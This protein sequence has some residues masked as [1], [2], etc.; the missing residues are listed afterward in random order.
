MKIV[1]L[2]IKID[3]LNEIHAYCESVY[4]SEAAGLLLGKVD[5]GR[6]IVERIVKVRNSRESSAQHNRYLITPQDM[7]AGENEAMRWDLDVVGIFHSHPDHPNRPSEFDRQWA[8]PW[9]SYIIT[10]VQQRIAIGSRS[11]FLADDRSSF[12]EE[13]MDVIYAEIVDS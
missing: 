12:E 8:L 9:Y 10:C 4:P 5:G 11:W 6:K 1:N 7:L 2:V 13:K 3:L